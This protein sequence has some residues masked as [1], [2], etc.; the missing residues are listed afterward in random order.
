MRLPSLPLRALLISSFIA[1]SI[2][3]AALVGWHMHS[4]HLH[5]VQEFSSKLVSD[6]AKRVQGDIEGHLGDAHTIFNGVLYEIPSDSQLVRARKMM[7]NL[8]EFEA[9]AF[10]LTRM[11]TNVPYM[12]AGTAKGEFLG[13]ENISKN[14]GN[15]LRVGVRKK[16]GEGQHYY[17]AF[18]PGDRSQAQSIESANY[19]PRTRPWYQSAMEAKGRTFTPIYLSPSK[20]QLVITLAQ[21]VYDTDTAALGV[22]AVDV[23]LKRLSELL[24]LLSISASGAAYLVDDKG[25]LV[26]SSTG[27]E[28]Y[29]EADDKLQRVSPAASSNASIRESFALLGA[30][31][32]KTE[33]ESVQRMSADKRLVAHSG[34]NLVTSL[35]P[36]GESLGLKWT[37]I[38]AAPESDFVGETQES[39]RKSLMILAVVITLA[40]SLAGLFA[41]R[42]NRRFAQLNIAAEQ[43]G[44]GEVPALQDNSRVT[45][46]STLSRVLHNSGQWLQTSRSEIVSKSQALEDA[47]EHL[48]ARVILRTVQLED[49]RDAAEAGARAK[50]A[51]LATM[52]HE[53]RTPLN[54]VVGMTTLMADTPLNAEQAD[55][56]HTMRVSSDQ[57]LGVINDILDFSKIE[58]GKLDLENEPLNLQATLEEACDI[59]A[60]RAREKGLELIAD[61]G[62]HMPLW[63]KGDVT[64]LRQVLINFINNSVKFTEHGQVVVHAILKEDFKPGADVSSGA[65]IE[66]R[67]KDTGIGIPSDRIGALFQSFSQVD[68][69]TTRKYGGTGL[70]LA[71]CKR[72]AAIMGGEVGVESE[73][74]KGS[75]FWFTARLG[76]ADAPDSSQTSLVQLTSLADKQVLVVDDTVLNLRILDKQLSRWSMDVKTFER[77][78]DA[79]LWLKNN[80]IDVIVTDMHMPEMDGYGFISA[81]HV[82]L[83]AQMPPV[84]LLTSGSMPTGETANLFD[85][86]FLKPYRQSQLFDSIVRVLSKGNLDKKPKAKA[87]TELKNQTILVAD[88]NA[89]NLKVAQAMLSKLGYTSVTASDGRVAAD[90]VRDSLGEGGQRYAAILMDANMPVMDGFESAREIIALYGANAPPILA[91]TASVLEEDRKRCLDSGMIGF[92]AK[93]LR[94]DELSSALTQYARDPALLF[95]KISLSAMPEVANNDHLV[96]TTPENAV[97]IAKDN[98]CGVADVPLMDWSRLEQF[99]EFDDEDRSMTREV[100]ALFIADAPKRAQDLVA[101]VTTGDAEVLSRAA[102][103]LKGA[104]SNV[105][106]TALTEAC[107]VLEHACT[108]GFPAQAAVHVTH[109]CALEEKTR[110]VLGKWA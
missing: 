58:S 105:G 16:D 102:H 83:G 23:Y 56:L 107:F 68:S 87:E 90:K 45:E 5:T 31:V 93:P 17:S 57:L 9:T 61:M 103:A 63:V 101:A 27:E 74:G 75:T 62:D 51:F 82:L 84:V 8:T 72:L 48:E 99:K 24:Q 86:K 40:A 77:P 73:L 44:R 71:I 47:N 50:A 35:R 25:F 11:S 80:P 39:M 13:V 92:L 20:K 32:G 85:A 53:I 76:Y 14:S 3:P 36:F 33:D 109:I 19:E 49:A 38:V 70:G 64:R 21:P 41:Y 55:Y 79:L 28:L 2:I 97:D 37:L 100:V 69:S 18:K 12:Y 78:A 43:L 94:L 29:T 104:A 1:F 91:L 65:L 30:L 54:G 88:D 26:A 110:D 89:V 96:M 22:I 4:S 6:V 81:A 42:L 95:N 46:L 34:E 15:F 52:S 106:A 59:A 98:G 7:S 10:T 60:P 67:V 108:E 66:F